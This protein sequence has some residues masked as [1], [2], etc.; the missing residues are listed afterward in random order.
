MQRHDL[1]VEPGD[2]RLGLANPFLH[3]RFLTAARGPSERE[4]A[5]FDPHDFRNRRI[6]G[7]GAQRCRENDRRQS[8]PLRD[9]PGFARFELVDIRAGHRRRCRTDPIV[10]GHQQLPLLDM[11]A[12]AHGQILDHAARRMTNLPNAAF[13]RH[14][15]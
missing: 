4:G 13:D 2:L 10:E 3:L 11:L 7:A 9:Q 5:L 6:L 14:F 8:V 12:F 1:I 15:A